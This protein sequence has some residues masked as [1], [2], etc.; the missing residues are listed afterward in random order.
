MKKLALILIFINLVVYS[1]GQ[2]NATS[3]KPITFETSDPLKVNA[4]VYDI[5]AA[6]KVS[7]E[8]ASEIKQWTLAKDSVMQEA[9]ILIS[10][11]KYKEILTLLLPFDK[12]NPIDASFY[13]ILG[14]AYYFQAYYN[15]ASLCL[16]NSY[17]LKKNN[18][19]IYL[20]AKSFE[21]IGNNK[22]AVKWYKKGRRENES[23]CIE[24][25]KIIEA[26][27]NIEYKEY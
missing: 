10:K 1:N 27:N 15:G 25:L 4:N 26:S 24:A 13:E 20:I 7:R 23:K 5:V 18:D 8:R 17:L 21:E 2:A 12:L 19:L 16:S 6:R 9:K 22:E 11:D 14:K 3:I